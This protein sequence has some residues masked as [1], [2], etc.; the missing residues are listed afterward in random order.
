[1]LLDPIV[2]RSD[3]LII[4]LR[5]FISASQRQ[6]RDQTLQTRPRLGPLL[7]RSCMWNQKQMRAASGVK[8][9]VG[10]HRDARR[11]FERKIWKLKTKSPPLVFLPD[12]SLRRKP[13]H[14]S[15]WH[16]RGEARR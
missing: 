13:H 10:A 7:A 5:N 14:E 15:S 6:L 16:C 3:G 2:G 4:G 8:P 9:D 11:A 1:M 12:S